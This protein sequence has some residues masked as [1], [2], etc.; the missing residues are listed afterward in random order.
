VSPDTEKVLDATQLADALI[1]LPGWELKGK[2]IVKTYTFKTFQEAMDFAN[3]VAQAA[4]QQNHHPSIHID[5]VKVKILS[6]THK[7]NAVT[8]L[9]IRLAEEIDKV[10]ESV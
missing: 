2:Q 9:D 5:H 8:K 3:R 1:D 7:F 6:W 10:F 4:E